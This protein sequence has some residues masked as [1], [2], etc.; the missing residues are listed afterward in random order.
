MAPAFPEHCMRCLL[1]AF[2]KPP[3]ADTG[4]SLED[5]VNTMAADAL[6]HGD[7]RD[8]SSQGIDYAR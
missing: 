7:R 2:C 6:A 5:G 1:W 3:G 4:I 8:S